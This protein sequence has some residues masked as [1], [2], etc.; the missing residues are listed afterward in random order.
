MSFRPQRDRQVALTTTDTLGGT[1]PAAMGLR[2]P[3]GSPRR[4]GKRRSPTC[5]SRCRRGTSTAQSPCPVASSGTPFRTLERHPSS[6]SGMARCRRRRWCRRTCRPTSTATLSKVGCRGRGGFCG[7]WTGSG[8]TRASPRSWPAWV[9]RSA[10]R[11]CL[12]LIQCFEIPRIHNISNPFI[13]PP[14]AALH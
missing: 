11:A 12:R 2:Q 1:S 10:L 14:A 8:A 4:W 9:P 7:C 5:R 3:T 6:G 13:C